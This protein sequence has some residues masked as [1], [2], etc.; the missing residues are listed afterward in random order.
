MQY[1]KAELRKVLVI[2]G[3]RSDPD[4]EGR[5]FNVLA[6]DATACN[7]SVKGEIMDISSQTENRVRILVADD[8]PS[9]RLY[10]SQILEQQEGWQVSDL[11]CN[12]VEAVDRV[13]KSRPDVVVLDFQMPEMNG[14]EVARSITEIEPKIPILM[15][16]LYLSKQV[17]DEARK[18]GIRGLAR[19]LICPAL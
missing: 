14:L 5:A 13:G 4:T 11:V 1:G 19:R 18:V 10:L 15:V 12:G 2:A 7:L 9:V 17:Y 8:N 6:A 3:K 16:T